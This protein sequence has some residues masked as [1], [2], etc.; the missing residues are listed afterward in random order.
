MVLIC[1]CLEPLWLWPSSLFVHLS[2]YL[3]HIFIAEGHSRA[4]RTFPSLED[5]AVHEYCQVFLSAAPYV[6][7]HSIL[8]LPNT[9]SPLPICRSTLCAC[10]ASHVVPR[11]SRPLVK[12]CWTPP[13]RARGSSLGTVRGRLAARN[14]ATDQT[15]CPYPH[16][17]RS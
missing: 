3:P 12:S 13:H 14:P 5:K 11:F 2:I 9:L 6:S 1:S 16:S 8:L 15:R 7:T 17:Q 10:S 4:F